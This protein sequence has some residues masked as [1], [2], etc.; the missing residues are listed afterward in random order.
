MQTV[1]RLRGRAAVVKRARRLA[2]EP[3]C[4]DCRA[5]GRVT[6]ATVPDH[7]IP[8]AMGGTDDESNIRCLCRDCHMVRTAEQFGM[9]P[10]RKQIGKDGWPIG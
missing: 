6:I 10:P 3:I 8:L 4:R 2:I 9:K 5:K 1:V 7:I